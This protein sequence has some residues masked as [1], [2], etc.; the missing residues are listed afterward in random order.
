MQ[1]ILL[2]LAIFT[3]GCLLYAISTKVHG[4]Q[5]RV[6]WLA[7]SV[8]TADLPEPETTVL[9]QLAAKANS[10]KIS[11]TKLHHRLHAE[12][13][14]IT[15]ALCAVPARGADAEE[16]SGH[17]TALSVLPTTHAQ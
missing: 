8:N 17:E 9:T 2:F 7:N 16:I 10:T 4:I 11:S 5:R 3:I 1:F 12:H 14:Q 13:Q 15:W 6:S